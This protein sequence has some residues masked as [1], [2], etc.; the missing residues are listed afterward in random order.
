ME[1]T[2]RLVCEAMEAER[3]LCSLSLCN[4]V[5]ICAFVHMLRD[6]PDLV[7]DKKFSFVSFDFPRSGNISSTCTSK[8]IVIIIII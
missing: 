1:P 2:E 7:L 8:K 6:G 4:V 5:S 3:S